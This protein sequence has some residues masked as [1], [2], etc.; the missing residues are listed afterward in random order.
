MLG[1]ILVLTL[2]VIGLVQGV[3][4]SKQR[5]EIEF[6]EQKLRVQMHIQMKDRITVTKLQKEV[7]LLD[8]S[9]AMI[10]TGGQKNGNITRTAG[11]EGQDIG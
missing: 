1:S 2:S 7:E 6:L 8:K 4:L 3:K 9:L 5:E 10:R 11:N